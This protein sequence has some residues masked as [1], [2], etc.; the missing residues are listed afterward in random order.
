MNHKDFISK[1]TGQLVDIDHVFWA[2]CIDLMKQYCLDVYWVPPKQAGNAVEAWKNKYWYFDQ[3][4]QYIEW[5]SPKQWDIVFINTSSEYEHV[6]IGHKLNELTVQIFDQIGNGSPVGWEK[7]CNLRLYPRKNILGYWRRKD[8]DV[9]EIEKRVDDFSK[10]WG[11][12]G[13]SKTKWYSQFEILV[14][15]SKILK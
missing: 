1:Y 7:P 5:D 3:N 4:W 14:I 11:I 13:K 12:V 9:D 2:E 6:G 8:K 10:K 15:L